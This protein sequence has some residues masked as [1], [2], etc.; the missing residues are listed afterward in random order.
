MNKVTSNFMNPSR[1]VDSNFTRRTV[2][3]ILK[4]GIWIN[5]DTYRFKRKRED[6]D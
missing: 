3:N 6:D 5:P 2:K 1:S 4:G